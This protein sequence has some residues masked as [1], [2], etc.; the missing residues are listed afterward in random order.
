MPPLRLGRSGPDVQ[1]WQCFLQQH[2]HYKVV[3]VDG[4]FGPQTRDA[5]QAFQ[6]RFVPAYQ[7]GHVQRWNNHTSFAQLVQPSGLVDPPTLMQA[8]SMGFL[9]PQSRQPSHNHPV[10]NA[11]HAWYV[12]VWQ[13][14]L[15]DVVQLTVVG[16]IDGDFGP[17]TEQATR[18]FQSKH[19]RQLVV[20]GIVGPQTLRVAYEYYGLVTLLI[21]Y[22]GQ[23]QGPDVA[24]WQAFLKQLDDNNDE[25]LRVDGWFGPRTERATRAFQDRHGLAPMD[26]IVGLDTWTQA[27]WMGWHLPSSPNAI[28]PF[29]SSS[30]KNRQ[31]SS[32]PP[33]NTWN[34]VLDISHYQTHVDFPTLARHGTIRAVIAKSTEGYGYTDPTYHKRRKQAMAAGLLWGAYHFGT[35]T[36]VTKQLNYFMS[37]VQPTVHN[38][39][40][41]VLDWEENP[42]GTQMTLP[43]ARA[44]CQGIHRRTGKWPVLYGGKLLRDSMKQSGGDAILNQCPLWWAEW[45]TTKSTQPTIPPGW[46]HYTLWQYTNGHRGPQPHTVA[47]VVPSAC[48]RSVWYHAPSLTSNNKKS[49]PQSPQTSKLKLVSHTNHQHHPINVTSTTTT[50]TTLKRTNAVLLEELEL[51][52]NRGF[53]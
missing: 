5:T 25:F 53:N 9:Q 31:S 43:Q 21:S 14:F 16:R 45:T 22:R 26:G 19:G 29:S 27:L 35:G 36:N 47:G 46:S 12:R 7:N 52:W 40:L 8:Q 42:H 11:C 39:T 18:A 50:T 32:F 49:R 30:N 28:V 2:Q 33:V 4:V 24:A 10:K 3:N 23:S 17:Q 38:T 6:R 48:D 1:A 20:D 13:G 15:R 51:A 44:F 41:L 34:V 37:V